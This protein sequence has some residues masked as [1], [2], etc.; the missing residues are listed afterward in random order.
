MAMPRFLLSPRAL[1]LA[2]MEGKKKKDEPY[3]FSRPSPLCVS[4]H[5][6]ETLTSTGSLRGSSL[7]TRRTF[8]CL[9]F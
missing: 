3:L 5:T 7:V 4:G 1:V 2:K 6:D 9:F 8:R